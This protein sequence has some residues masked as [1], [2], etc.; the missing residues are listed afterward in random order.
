MPKNYHLTQAQAILKFKTA[1]TNAKTEPTLAKTLAEF[2]YTTAKIAEGEALLAKTEQ[3]VATG[4]QE[5]KE[6][7]DAYIK[8][9]RKHKHTLEA[10]SLDRKKAHVVFRHQ[11]EIRKSLG[12]HNT[13]NTSLAQHIKMMK[14]FYTLLS[15]N[16]ELAKPL[17]TLKITPAH[18]TS[19]LAEITA[20]E[21]AI[22]DYHRERGESEQAIA[23][24]DKALK[25]LADWMSEL[26]A[27]ARIAFA[28]NPQML[29]ALNKTAK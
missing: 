23:D 25:Q 15:Q 27:V 21:Q 11:P 24:K 16:T 5:T 17:E 14:A 1:L 13:V 8:Y 12:I 20:L 18:I 28:D 4:E 19:Q 26:F 2:G 9:Y 7:N 6:K 22:A 3:A 10:Y 29:E